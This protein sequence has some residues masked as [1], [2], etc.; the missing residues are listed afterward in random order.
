MAITLHRLRAAPRAVVLSVASVGLLGIVI[1]C[2]AIVSIL[3]APVTPVDLDPPLTVGVAQLVR[4]YRNS[5]NP[6]YFGYYVLVRGKVV[7]TDPLQ[8]DGHAAVYEERT[9]VETRDVE[10]LQKQG[11]WQI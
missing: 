9:I 4:M 7:G 6:T 5:R 11:G 8:V 10:S 1:G 3:S 2:V